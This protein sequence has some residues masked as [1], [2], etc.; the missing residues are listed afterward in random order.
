[1]DLEGIP[2]T[3]LPLDQP[4]N[5][6]LFPELSD[7]EPTV[8]PTPHDLP[9][10]LIHDVQ[11]PTTTSPLKSPSASVVSPWSAPSQAVPELSPNSENGSNIESSSG[12]GQSEAL[13]NG[14]AV[15]TAL[16]VRMSL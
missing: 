7:L 16:R 9:P 12:E 15:H 13:A 4:P 11:P 10:T 1:M 14:T 8:P 6:T 5:A 3:V 2:Y